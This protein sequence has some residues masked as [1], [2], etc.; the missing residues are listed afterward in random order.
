MSH[1]QAVYLVGSGGSGGSVKV[2]K[3]LVSISV[4][5]RVLVVCQF[6]HIRVP[7]FVVA[8]TTCPTYCHWQLQDHD[9]TRLGTWKILGFSASTVTRA[10]LPR[11]E[12][13]GGLQSSDEVD[14]EVIDVRVVIDRVADDFLVDDTVVFD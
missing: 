4:V 3:G 10:H 12:T 6:G 1:L 2:N 11:P 14:D 7:H 8:L 9:G 13:S 5:V